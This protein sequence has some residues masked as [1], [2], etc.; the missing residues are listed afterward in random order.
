MVMS[1]IGTTRRKRRGTVLTIFNQKGGVGKTTTAVN[2]SA[3]MAAANFRVLLIDLDSQGNASTALGIDRTSRGLGAYDF[4]LGAGDSAATVRETAIPG[5]SLVTGSMDLVGAEMELSKLGDRHAQLSDRL[6]P[7]RGDYDFILIDCPPSFGFL[8][9]NA[10]LAAD[11]LLVPVQCE[12]LSLEGLS[13]LRDTVNLLRQRFVPGFTGFDI[14]ITMY[15][16]TNPKA[17]AL[18]GEMRRHFA[19]SVYET[20]VPRN[21]AISESAAFGTPVLL[22]RAESEGADAYLNVSAEILIR[23]GVEVSVPVD[24]LYHAAAAYAGERAGGGSPAQPEDEPARITRD[25]RMTLETW[26]KRG[27][28]R[29]PEKEPAV[30]VAGRPG[31]VVSDLPA[32]SKT[33][34]QIEAQELLDAIA[35]K[36][37]AL[38]V[39]PADRKGESMP[40]G[41]PS[42]TATASWRHR[43]GF[44]RPIAAPLIFIGMI[45]VLF[46]LQYLFNRTPI[47]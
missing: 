46:A 32:R 16:Q 20:M 4:L 15:E 47:P 22:Y 29:R 38:K 27:V 19:G 9:L 24:R 30:A 2:V 44:A 5:L 10:I 36:T 17:Q 42:M 31:N 8:A 12:Y 6:K 40:A 7:I 11:R 26:F 41:E 35:Q 14:L 28:Y 33:R 45:A 37:A 25:M 43:L 34:R 3:A 13:H 21:E 39:E 23:E 18:A 1:M